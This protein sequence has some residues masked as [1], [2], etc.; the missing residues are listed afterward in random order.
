ML[1]P[2]PRQNSLEFYNFRCII[3]MFEFFEPRF[4]VDGVAFV[5]SFVFLLLEER[6]G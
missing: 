3:F 2:N 1:L 4:A 6:W 5:P